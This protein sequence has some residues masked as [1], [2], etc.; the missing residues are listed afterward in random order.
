MPKLGLHRLSRRRLTI[1]R[2]RELESALE[3]ERIET[4]A[5]VISATV[6]A[7]VG[8]AKAMAMAMDFTMMDSVVALA[9]TKATVKTISTM[10][11]VKKTMAMVGMALGMAR[12]AA[13]GVIATMAGQT[14]DSEDSEETIMA[15][16]TGTLATQM[17]GCID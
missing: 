10:A 16:I 8:L 15:T 11:M 12:T 5:I 14:L 17:T 3:S 1:H 7:M 13:M 4:M 2:N 6:T 9:P